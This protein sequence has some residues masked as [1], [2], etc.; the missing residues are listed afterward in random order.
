M[1]FVVKCSVIITILAL[2]LNTT[3]PGN[4]A[5]WACRHLRYLRAM[6]MHHFVFVHAFSQA[7]VELIDAFFLSFSS[8]FALTLIVIDGQH[9]YENGK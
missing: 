1:Q 6:C 9:T 3:L 7:N 4:R 5:L 8:L 2:G